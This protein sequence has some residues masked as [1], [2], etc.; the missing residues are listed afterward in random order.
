MADNCCVL[1]RTPTGVCA[2]KHACEHHQ[3]AQAQDEV[4]ARARRTHPDPT[5]DQAIRN[6]LAARRPRAKR[7]PYTYRRTQ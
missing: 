4:N 2:S 1:C 3:I 6:A 7:A 5:A